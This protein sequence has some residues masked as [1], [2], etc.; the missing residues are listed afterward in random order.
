MYVCTVCIYCIFAS[1]NGTWSSWRL[2]RRI[3][4]IR[5]LSSAIH[6]TKTQKN[7][8]ARQI[9]RRKKEYISTPQSGRVHLCRFSWRK[10]H[11]WTRIPWPC[12]QPLHRDRRPQFPSP[13]Q[14]S[15]ALSTPI[16]RAARENTP[17]E[18]FNIQHVFTD[19]MWHYSVILYII[20]YFGMEYS[21]NCLQLFICKFSISVVWIYLTKSLNRRFSY[22]Y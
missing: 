19:R 7:C 8:Y 13:S 16:Q 20:G 14:C 5:P 9:K 11:L 17:L 22:P 6:T 1:F 4:H 3:L 15:C 18:V 12:G 2:G 10:T 21:A